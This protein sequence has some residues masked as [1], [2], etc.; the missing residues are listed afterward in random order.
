MANNN[1]RNEYLRM[2]RKYPD[3]LRI[4][5]LCEALGGISTKTG[6]KLLQERKINCL[7]VGREYRATKVDSINYLMK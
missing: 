5:Q 2:F 3:L 7:K 4:E 6:Y 1:Q